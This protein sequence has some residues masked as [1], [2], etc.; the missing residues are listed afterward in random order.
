MK[1]ASTDRLLALT[2]TERLALAR[3]AL[4]EYR[5]RCFWFLSPDFDVTEETLDIIVS[6]LRRQGDRRAFLIADRLCR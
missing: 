1:E 3:E 5:A 6:G 2:A 4:A